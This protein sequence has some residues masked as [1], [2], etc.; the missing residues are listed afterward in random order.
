MNYFVGDK[1]RVIKGTSDGSKTLDGHTFKIKSVDHSSENKNRM[2][3]TL[4]DAKATKVWIE[5]IQPYEGVPNMFKQVGSDLKG[6]IVEHKSSIYWIAVLFLVDYFFF[7][8]AFR[9]RLHSLMNKMLGK[10]ESA[11]EGKPL[12]VV[13]KKA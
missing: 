4:D 8:G 11:V 13:E 9:E 2:F 6:F 3:V 10:V 7:N 12:A 1:V 5:E